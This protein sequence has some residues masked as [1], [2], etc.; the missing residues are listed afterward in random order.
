MAQK[1]INLDTRDYEHPFD[2]AALGTVKRI[3]LL[4]AVAAKAMNL[5]SVKWS[6][7]ALCGSNYHV[8]RSACPTLYQ[9]CKDVIQTLD[10]NS[11]PDIYVEQDYYVNAYTTGV[12][13][14]AYIVLSSGAVDRLS[15]KE[16]QFIVGHEAGHIKSGHVLYHIMCA[17][18]GELAKDSALATVF[19]AGLP[20][21]LQYWNRMSE[22]TAD[23]AGLLA[24]QDLEQAL[25]VIMKM[26]G[27]PM[28]YYSDA[29]LAGFIEQAREFN[30]KY[31][32][33]FDTVVRNLSILGADHPWTVVRAA[34][35]IKWV[36]AGEY[37]RILKRT[38]GKICANDGSQVPIDAM[39]CPICGGT[40]FI[41]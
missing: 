36:E 20:L 19:T 15:E 10:L 8:T 28:K 23:R 3:P 29:S 7:I 21:A 38:K 11:M 1:L 41:E 4:P 16:L 33:T 32:G 17:Y 40:E 26:S 31:S 30:D 22:F 6:I 9:S 37:D 2:R 13:R 14:T 27:L 12:D 24:C 39:V 34:E 5:L 25:N 18:I 35:L